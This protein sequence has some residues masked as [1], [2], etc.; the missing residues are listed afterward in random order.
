[1]PHEVTMP[2]LGMA[3]DTGLV[4]SWAK[5][6]GDPVKTGDVLM[7]VETDKSTMELEAA[8]DGYLAEIRAAVGEA[9][10][11]GEIIAVI[12]ESTDDIVAAGAGPVV[13]E[14]GGN[15]SATVPEPA[16]PTSQIAMEPGTATVR[17]AASAPSDRILASAKAKYMA[18]QRGIDL[19]ALVRRGAAQPIHVADLEQPNDIAALGASPGTLSAL[20]DRRPMEE[21]VAWTSEI[22][23]RSIAESTVWLNF[24]TRVLR[25]ATGLAPADGILCEYARYGSENQAFFS[26]DADRVVLSC[27]RTTNDIAR[28]ADLKVLDLSPTRVSDYR[29]AGSH[30]APTIVLGS[31]AEGHFSVSLHFREEQLPLETAIAMLDDLAR[32]VAEPMKNLL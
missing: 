27:L 31:A 8:H 18:A 9:V 21:F 12:S 16:P 3:Q 11:V 22:A 17:S 15:G 6:L 10:P 5:A 2:Q 25:N 23:G 7:E 32:H 1:M 30:A 20:V 14:T 28:V 19:R 13:P 26:V 29:P 4:V 24:A